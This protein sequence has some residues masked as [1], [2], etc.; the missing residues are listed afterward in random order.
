M[1]EINLNR[2]VPVYTPPQKPTEEAQPAQPAA[3]LPSLDVSKSVPVSGPGSYQPPRPDVGDDLK[4]SAISGAQKSVLGIPGMMGDIQ[5]VPG[6][7]APLA[8]EAAIWARKKVGMPFSPEAE[9]QTREAAG[10]MGEVFK[11]APKYN[12]PSALSQAVGGPPLYAPTTEQISKA[13]DPYVEQIAPG[14]GPEYKPKTA[15]GR[16]LKGGLELAAPGAVGPAKG[17]LRRGISALAGGLGSEA[18]GE[19]AKG[20]AYETPAR[21]AGALVGGSASDTLLGYL[22]SK[23]MVM[24]KTEAKRQLASGLEDYEIES[25]ALAKRMAQQPGVG[26]AADT[27]MPRMRQ[28]TQN[29]LGVDEKAGALTSRLIQ[30]GYDLRDDMYNAMNALP[31]AQS[32]DDTL[33]NPLRSSP[34]FK[35]AEKNARENT[36]IL[37]KW[38]VKVPEVT[39]GKPAVEDAFVQTERGLQKV[40]GSAAIPETVSNG[41]LKYYDQVKR[42][43]DGIIEQAHRSGDTTR[44]AEAEELKRRLLAVTDDAVPEYARV[45]DIAS[46]TFTASSAPEA[47]MKFYNMYDDL[48]AEDVKKALASYNPEQRTAF[49]VGFM[50]KLEQELASKNTKGIVSR[51]LKN[52]D[53]MEKLNLV[54]G[55]EAAGAIR[56][57]VLAENLIQQAD[58]MRTSEAAQA[59]LKSTKTSSLVPAGLAFLG[60]GA[61]VEAQYLAGLIQQLGL[62]KDAAIYGGL[63]AVAAGGT[64]MVMRGF[65][66]RVA[67]NMLE[68]AKSNKPR[69]FKRLNTLMQNYPEVYPKL[70]MPLIA[71]EELEAKGQQAQQ[72]KP[73]ASGGRIER[74]S[75]GRV[76]HHYHAARL[77]KAAELAKKNHGKTTETILNAPDEHVVKALAVANKHIEG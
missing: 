18:G 59:A 5:Q 37:E 55:P 51:F 40:P 31:S 24:P 76:G 48:K 28:F 21:F 54:F 29:L 25:S 72:P 61:A 13:V 53:F 73:Q 27:L 56:G 50:T 39:P 46:N 7:I 43:L 75:G 4:R 33:F 23:G 26:Q 58:R 63:A 57:K 49:G 14:Y 44:K 38:G 8:G 42:E 74:K 1:A 52:D 32:I 16:I 77:V 9:A 69:D 70:L 22:G 10:K 65:E 71:I 20:T 66:K 19:Y 3:P 62:S 41:N 45:R 30:E 6:L 2:S 11:E 12:L 17:V 47:G 68:L 15:E 35:Q 67:Q 64:S 36:A 34:V 60:T